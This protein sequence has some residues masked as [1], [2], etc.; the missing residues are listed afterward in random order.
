MRLKILPLLAV[1]AAFPPLPAGAAVVGFTGIVPGLAVYRK[2]VITMREERFRGMIHQHTDFSCGAAALATIL[3][4]A[5]GRPV[6]ERQVLDGLFKVSD[7]SLVRRRGFSLLDLKHYVE[8][9]GYRGVGYRVTLA[10]LGDVRVPTIVL[11]DI[12]GYRHFVV[13]RRVLHGRY[14][15][16]DPALGNRL[17]DRADFARAWNGIIF[18]VIGPGYERNTS[19]REPVGPPSVQRFGLGAPLTDTQLYEFGFTRADLF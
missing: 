9:L 5:Y 2:A 12:R 19:L 18:A 15:L 17:M 3:H 1:T 14:Y 13:L 4:Y 11:L 10:A 7:A 16:A 6:Q 8:T